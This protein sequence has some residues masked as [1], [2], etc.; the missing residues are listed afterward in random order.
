LGYL[1]VSSHDH[2]KLALFLWT[3]QSKAPV[4]NANSWDWKSFID[5][6]DCTIEYK[7][8]NYFVDHMLLR[9]AFMEQEQD[10]YE[11][12]IFIL[13]RLRKPIPLEPTG[14]DYREPS[15]NYILI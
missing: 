7:E 11:P 8:L 9:S 13:A 2:F 5:C 10:L 3:K 6:A 12:L 14:R 1:I 15:S 4:L